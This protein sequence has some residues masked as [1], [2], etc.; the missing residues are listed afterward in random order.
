MAYRRQACA[1]LLLSAAVL[2]AQQPAVAPE[3]HNPFVGDQQAIKAGASLFHGEC[4]YCHGRDARGGSRGP[5]LTTGEFLHGGSDAELQRT[6]SRGVPGTT[7]GGHQM[8]DD[9]LWQIVSFL[10]TLQAPAP[11]ATGKAAHGREIFFGDGNCSLCHMVNGRGGRLG[12]DLSH[13]GSA[14]PR[15]YLVESVRAPDKTLTLNHNVDSDTF[16]YDT[17]TLETRDGRKLTGVPLNEDTFSVQVMDNDE[18]IHSFMKRELKSY[19]REAK[20]MMPA[21]KEDVLSD[22][23]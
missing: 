23:D 20:S 19:R 10:R 15:P 22:R 14:R 8:R 6:I 17:V 13:V 11:A 1:L 7:M 4:I 16:R 5:D 2:L 18:N 9:E 3:P 12:P 21:L